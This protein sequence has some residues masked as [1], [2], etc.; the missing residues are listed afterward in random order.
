MLGN[1][2]L[3]AA[4]ASAVTRRSTS[5]RGHGG[6]GLAGRSGLQCLTEL[7]GIDLPFP[8]RDKGSSVQLNSLEHRLSIIRGKLASNNAGRRTDSDD[9]RIRNV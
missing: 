2:A 1:S 7:D 9:R 6:S 3:G 4:S 8:I 5:L